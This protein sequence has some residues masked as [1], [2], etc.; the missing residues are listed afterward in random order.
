MTPGRQVWRAQVTI[1]IALVVAIL[2]I[3]TILTTRVRAA[4]Y[5]PWPTA[6]QTKPPGCPAWALRCRART[7]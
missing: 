3:V 4:D 5:R 2:F 1:I 7:K 6:E